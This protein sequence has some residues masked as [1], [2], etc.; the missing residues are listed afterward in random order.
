MAKITVAAGPSNLDAELEQ[1]GHVEPEVAEGEA[2][3]DNEAHAL[4]SDGDGETTE[5]VDYNDFTVEDL[6]AELKERGLPTSGNKP[7]LVERLAE[8]DGEKLTADSTSVQAG[9][10]EGSGGASS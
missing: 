5:V 9:A 6:R 3:E 4:V 7:E 2:V 1:P 10:A 8:N